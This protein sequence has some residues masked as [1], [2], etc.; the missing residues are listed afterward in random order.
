MKDR[1]CDFIAEL[2]NLGMIYI[3]CM[4]ALIFAE[5][6]LKSTITFPCALILAALLGWCFFLRL[7]IENFILYVILH[8]VPAAGFLF[9]P[10]EMGKVELIAI[11]ALFVVLDIAFWVKRKTGGFAYIPVACVALNALAYL[12]SDIK[13]Y[14]VEMIL[15]FA[16]GISFFL[17]FYVRHFFSHASLLAK[18]RTQDER[19]PFADMLKNGAKVA[20][21]FVLL[22]VAAMILIKIDALDKYALIV[23]NVIARIL[24]FVIRI[25]LQVIHFI[26]SLIMPDSDPDQARVVLEAFEEGDSNI[27]L[28]ILS[29]VVYVT[30][31]VTVLYVLA[32]III[33]IIKMI[34]MKRSLTP[35][36]IEESDMV[37]IRE[38]IVKVGEEKGEKL[39]AIRKRYKKTVE[40]AAKRGY[41]L[42]RAHTPRER[43]GDF[44]EKTGSDIRELTGEYEKVRYCN[45]YL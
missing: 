32:K 13:K 9:I 19:M 37:E 41:P 1:N 42:N 22:S 27:F 31:L 40:K 30:G 11:Y 17:L 12:Y 8:L 38:R 39:S 16:M 24:G 2:A 6:L 23:Y 29:A 18:E 26:A 10:F 36:V 33:A 45:K 7:K 3:F 5:L 15:F 35:Q 43:A 4:S 25:I 14:N 21:P 20:F 28:R 44:S 34:P